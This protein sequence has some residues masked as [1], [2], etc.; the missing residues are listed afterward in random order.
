MGPESDLGVVD[1]SQDVTDGENS[2]ND[3]RDA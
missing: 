1:Q 2:E 3:A